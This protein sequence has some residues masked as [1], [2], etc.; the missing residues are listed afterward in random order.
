MQKPTAIVVDDDRDVLEMYAG[1]LRLYGLNVVEMVPDGRRALEC[2]REYRPDIV[3]MDIVMPGCNGL[4]VLEAMRVDRLPTRAILMTGY[5]DE[6]WLLRA[7]MYGAHA[8]LNKVEFHLLEPA[9]KAVLAGERFFCSW[10]DGVLS[11]ELVRL[12]SEKSALTPR[13]MEV[14]KLRV[15]GDTGKEIAAALVLSTE[16]VEKH[17]TNT[18]YTAALNKYDRPYYNLVL[19]SAISGKDA[20]NFHVRW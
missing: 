11:R 3:L 6:A 14:L 20:L 5:R 18:R 7:V 19:K 17:V 12:I 4:D 1:L 8:F 13:E 15:K 16:A 9:V 10:S 2:L